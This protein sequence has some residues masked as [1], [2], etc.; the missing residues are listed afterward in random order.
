MH[1]RVRKYAGGK[2]FS[3][4]NRSLNGVRIYAG[5]REI[6]TPQML[7]SASGEI[8]ITL[9]GSGGDVT[10]DWGDGNKTTH[11]LTEG[12]VD[13][14]HDYGGAGTRLIQIYGALTNVIYIKSINGN[15]VKISS[16]NILTLLNYLDLGL[17]SISDISAL[18]GLTNILQ[19]YIST[20][21]IS[22]ISILSS[23][24]GLVYLELLNN[25]ISD[26]SSL[27]GLSNLVWL[28]VGNN[29]VNYPLTGLTWFTATSG[30]FRFNST[31]ASSA[32]VDRWLIDL[33]AANWSN[34]I[35]YLNGT[36]PARTSDS[37]AAVVQLVLAG[38]TLHLN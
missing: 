17:N 27:T 28:H 23:F 10:I 15:I 11:T 22:N 25:N 26:I 20:N 2:L 37:D 4:D 12:G 3:G 36:N 18:G 21:T 13:F 34:C 29:P 32:E 7:C 1:N 24:T 8:T 33:A 16:F 6:I 9:K 35:V 14:V 19:L 38:V 31:V 5:G 30:T